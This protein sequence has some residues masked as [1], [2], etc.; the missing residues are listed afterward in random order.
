MSDMSAKHF[1]FQGFTARDGSGPRSGKAGREKNT[2]LQRG[3]GFHRSLHLQN[4]SF[5]R[6]GGK[7]ARDCSKSQGP[8]VT[9]KSPQAICGAKRRL[10]NVLETAAPWTGSRAMPECNR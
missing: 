8:K 4:T 5:G 6:W 10:R 9:R 7:S 2:R 3:L 1:V